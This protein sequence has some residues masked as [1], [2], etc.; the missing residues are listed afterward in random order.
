MRMNPPN[1]GDILNLGSEASVRAA[2]QVARIGY[3]VNSPDGRTLEW[4]PT[5]YEICGVDETEVANNPRLWETLV[6]PEDLNR[7]AEHVEMIASGKQ[8]HDV[9]FTIRT[10]AGE[11]RCLKASGSPVFRDGVVVAQVGVVVDIT[12][13]EPSRGDP[14]VE[15]DRAH[16]AIRESHHRVKNNLLTLRALINLTGEETQAVEAI[17]KQL[18][19]FIAAEDALTISDRRE[20]V[21]GEALLSKVVEPNHAL[22]RE[23]GAELHVNLTARDLPADVAIPLALIANELITNAIKHGIRAG[24]G[25][26]ITVNT[27]GSDEAY[28]VTVSN[29]GNPFKESPTTTS[30]SRGLGL[31]TRLAAQIDGDLDIKRDPYTTISVRVP[32]QS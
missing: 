22:I 17:R 23:L 26:S 4:N 29:S 5:L 25:D 21:D 15:K 27:A 16:L 12:T 6:V 8:V 19:A 11:S 10:P 20:R 18:D 1:K 3:W 13:E 31:V 9:Q 7:V 30:K 2:L 24:H 28:T 14:D 32:N